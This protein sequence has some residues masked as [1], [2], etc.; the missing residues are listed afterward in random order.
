MLDSVELKSTS[1][2]IPSQARFPCRKCTFIPIHHL[3]TVPSLSF[4]P[5]H[6]PKWL[7]WA[8][9]LLW[10]LCSQSLFPDQT[11]GT[12][13]WLSRVP[14]LL[15]KL[16]ELERARL[17]A[18]C[19]QIMC[20]SKA[21]SKLCCLSVAEVQSLIQQKWDQTSRAALLFLSRGQRLTLSDLTLCSWWN[22]W[23]PPPLPPPCMGNQKFEMSVNSHPVHEAYGS[24]AT[25]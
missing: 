19:L 17:R 6:R 23:R 9:C 24:A 14:M 20:P 7:C 4:A 5:C 25:D 12:Q 16:A 10:R 13:A 1:V 11:S 22:T 15:K 3:C 21:C 18:G 2:Y 8:S